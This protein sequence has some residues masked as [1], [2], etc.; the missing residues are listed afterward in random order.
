[1]MK[2]MMLMIGMM[3]KMMIIMN[4]KKKRTSAKLNY[5]NNMK[6]LINSHN[7]H[8]TPCVLLLLVRA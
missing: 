1:M 7:M 2:M 5:I 4:K 3:T 8:T 6:H